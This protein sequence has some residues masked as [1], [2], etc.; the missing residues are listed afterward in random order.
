MQFHNQLVEFQDQS[1][2]VE[3]LNQLVVVKID[4]QR[5]VL[6]NDN[7]RLGLQ[8][9]NQLAALQV[10][11]QLVVL[12]V[13][14]QLVVLQVDNLKN[15]KQR[16]RSA[17]FKRVTAP[18]LHPKKLVVLQVDNQRVVLRNDNQLVVLL[19]E[20]RPHQLEV[21]MRLKSRRNMTPST[22]LSAWSLKVWPQTFHL[23]RMMRASEILLG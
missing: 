7:Q 12:Q 15:D 10:D 18:M 19:L 23:T 21:T 6:R 8:V 5:V 20:I 11:N 14:N 1:V 4:N 13:D 16:R 17:R 9:D 22:S 2:L 3:F